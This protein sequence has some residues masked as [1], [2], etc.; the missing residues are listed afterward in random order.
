[1]QLDDDALVILEVGDRAAFN[2]RHA[3]GDCRIVAAKIRRRGQIVDLALGGNTGAAHIS[4]RDAR[5]FELVLFLV[6]AVV[7]RAVTSRP[8]GRSASRRGDLADR[9]LERLEL[10]CLHLAKIE[11]AYRYRCTPHR[12]DTVEGH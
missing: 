6:L 10:H 3:R 2:N 5:E 12:G 7:K 8:I 1:M 4:D 11:I 9:E